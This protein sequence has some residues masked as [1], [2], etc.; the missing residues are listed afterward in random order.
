SLYLNTEPD[1]TGRT[2]HGLFLRRELRDRVATY[3]DSAERE[4]L[5]ADVLR[6]EQFVEN[7][8]APSTR[9]VAIFACTGAA[10]FETIQLEVPFERH[11][12]FINDRAHLFPLA[13]L[14]DE[15]P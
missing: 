1:G 14:D 8:L 6:I 5:E 3:S 9:G 15:Y 11:E 4:S 10:L 7:E 12:L 2:N 13:R